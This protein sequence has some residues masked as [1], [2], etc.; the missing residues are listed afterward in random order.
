MSLWG[1]LL[2]CPGKLSELWIELAAFKLLFLPGDVLIFVNFAVAHPYCFCLG[3]SSDST[4]CMSGIMIF[5]NIP[6]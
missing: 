1:G 5:V 3:I 2:R 6:A 4:Q